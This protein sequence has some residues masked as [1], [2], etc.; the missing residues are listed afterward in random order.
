MKITDF[1]YIAPC[2]LVEVDRRFRDAYCSHHQDNSCLCY[3]EPEH[4][5][6]PIFFSIRLRKKKKVLNKRQRNPLDVHK[7]TRR[8]RQTDCAP[9]TVLNNVL[10]SPYLVL[11]GRHEKG[12][13]L[14]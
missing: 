2:S 9:S 14:L 6:D 12:M 4:I 11:Y 1:W 5:S 3:Y 8:L 10:L 13:S 7:V